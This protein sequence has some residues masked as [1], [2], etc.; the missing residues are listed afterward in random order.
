[1][2]GQ[3]GPK[4]SRHDSRS[5]PAAKK[6]PFGGSF[7]AQAVCWRREES[8]SR[9]ARFHVLFSKAQE[10][11]EALPKPLCRWFLP[12]G[13]LFLQLVAHFL[14]GHVPGLVALA[15]KDHEVG[16]RV[17]PAVCKGDSMV[18]LKPGSRGLDLALCPA[19][20]SAHGSAGT[21]GSSGTAWIADTVYHDP[22]GIAASVLPCPGRLFRW[23]DG[24]PALGTG[25]QDL[26]HKVA[27]ALQDRI[28]VRVADRARN[29]A[30][31]LVEIRIEL[32]RIPQHKLQPFPRPA[33]H[34]PC[35]MVFI[36]LERSATAPA[37]GI[38]AARTLDA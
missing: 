21:A 9:P 35:R 27:G 32:L 3:T 12:D 4:S 20:D 2:G 38:P 8:N 24:C 31:L 28:A 37:D 17:L 1:M 26:A 5:F 25:P 18:L 16:H 14:M 33:P 36:W 11:P 29:Y 23:S 10:V 6:P 19:A 7:L 15:A 34:P 22:C 13:C 30:G